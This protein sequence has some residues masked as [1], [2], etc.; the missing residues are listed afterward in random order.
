MENK[1]TAL[2]AFLGGQ[3][4]KED[5]N[6]LQI[7][8]PSHA[9]SYPYLVELRTFNRKTTIRFFT[10]IKVKFVGKGKRLL[11][12]L[13]YDMVR[14]YG[15][16]VCFNLEVDENTLNGDL[17]IIL[18]QLIDRADQLRKLTPSVPTFY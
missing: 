3:F 5:G 16:H 10:G 9:D 1:K 2:V 7:T 13:G 17:K 14:I 8:L 15:Q 11:S 18:D 6:S 4:V 12:E